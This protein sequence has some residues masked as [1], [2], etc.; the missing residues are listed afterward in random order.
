MASAGIYQF[1]RKNRKNKSNKS[2]TRLEMDGGKIH[3]LLNPVSLTRT[4]FI[5]C[6]I[7]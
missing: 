3:S 5:P 1:G 7:F 4:K 6:K 2:N